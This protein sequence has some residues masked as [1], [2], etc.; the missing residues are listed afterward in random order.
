MLRALIT[1]VILLLCLAGSNLRVW[2]IEAVP[3]PPGRPATE[4]EEQEFLALYARYS[5]IIGEAHVSGDAS[6][7]PTLFIN[8]PAYDMQERAPGCL[9]IIRHYWEQV[10]AVLQTVDDPPQQAGTGLL[11][12]KI[13]GNLYHVESV[14]DWAAVRATAEAEGHPPD[15]DDLPDG[16]EPVEPPEPGT[17]S[18]TPAIR[19]ATIHGD[20]ATVEYA[21]GS[22]HEHLLLRQIDGQWYVAGIWTSGSP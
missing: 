12:C 2:E 3:L 14:E 16:F 9:W 20:Y 11:S 8:D 22:W 7:F 18:V 4:A 19:D 1:A 10:D 21:F 15:P 6:A 17:S 5:R 13:A